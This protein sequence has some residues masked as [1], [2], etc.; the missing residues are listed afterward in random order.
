MT[1]YDL[2]NCIVHIITLIFPMY[3]IKY[4]N[5][6]FLLRCKR[7]ITKIITNKHFFV[8]GNGGHPKNGIPMSFVNH[9]CDVEDLV[10]ETRLVS[11]KSM[12]SVV[13]CDRS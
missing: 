2:C 9:G 13:C 5:D 8:S 3:T 10:N 7:I 1:I 4:Q 11:M 12:C 6:S